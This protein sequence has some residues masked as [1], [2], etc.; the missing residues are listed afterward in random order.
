MVGIGS[1]PATLIIATASSTEFRA[2]AEEVQEE[3]EATEIHCA[4]AVLVSDGFKR[5]IFNLQVSCK[6]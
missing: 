1:Y 5:A 2:E 3:S 6:Y 4:L